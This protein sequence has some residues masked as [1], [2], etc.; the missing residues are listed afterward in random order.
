MDSP[1]QY[2]D[3]IGKP[4]AWGG[5]GPDCYD[6]YGLV[7]TML[8]RIG[9]KNIPD[10]VSPSQGPRIIAL[11]MGETYVWKETE[12]RPG[13]V[14]LIKVPMSMH[15]GFILPYGKMI[16]A[17]HRSGGVVVEHLFDWKRRIVGYYEYV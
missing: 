3:L 11:M 13:T 12:A 2:E 1:I 15:V 17:W 4:F 8:E 10:Y 16:H 6:C 5:R 14:A 7:K 9:H